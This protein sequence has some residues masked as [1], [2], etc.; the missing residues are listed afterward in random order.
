MKYV[1]VSI[2]LAGFFSALEI[3]ILLDEPN[4]VKLA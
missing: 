2:L 4:Q 1:S 3:Y